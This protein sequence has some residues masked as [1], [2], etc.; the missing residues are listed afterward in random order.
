[1]TIIDLSQYG[2]I[3]S[4]EAVAKKIYDQIVEALRNGVVTIDMKG[5]KLMAT[6]CSKQIFGCLYT[7]L[8]G[9]VFYEK[10]HVQNASENVKKTIGIGIEM[11]LANVNK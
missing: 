7:N 11:T 5:I 1:M 6:F 9:E 3:V 10:I 2:P 8:G 4:N